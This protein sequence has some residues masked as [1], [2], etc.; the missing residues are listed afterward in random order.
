MAR[1][2]ATSKEAYPAVSQRRGDRK[3]P[4]EEVVEEAE[5]EV[6]GPPT[7]RTIP[8][9][10]DDT[11]SIPLAVKEWMDDTSAGVQ[12]YRENEDDAKANSGH[13]TTIHHQD[14]D[15]HLNNNLNIVGD[16]IYAY[17]WRVRREGPKVS[18]E[19]DQ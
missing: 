7:S 13:P 6:E 3:R 19:N 1:S 11:E 8:F 12:V 10:S 15:F 9:G 18:R 17:G 14:C 5:D 16:R 4:Y 2:D